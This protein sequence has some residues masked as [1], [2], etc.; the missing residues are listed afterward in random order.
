MFKGKRSQSGGERTEEERRL[1]REER[2]R[3]RGASVSSDP[4]VE[5]PSPAQPIGGEVGEPSGGEGG[6][7]TAEEAPPTVEHAMP[8][9]NEPLALAEQSELTEPFGPLV[10]PFSEE[11]IPASPSEA[12]MPIE[13][14]E[15]EE[16]PSEELPAQP[17]SVKP[18]VPAAPRNPR[19]AHRVNRLRRQ[20]ASSHR[21]YRRWAI[22]ILALLA[23]AAVVVAVLT[24]A[25]SPGDPKPAPVLP[26][27]VR[28]TIPEGFT[29]AQIAA[30][31]KADGLQG[32][33]L[34]ASVRSSLLHPARYGAPSGTQT[35]EGFLF[36][37]TY[38]LYAGV[39]AT[40]LVDEQLL[41]FR[42][43][44]NDVEIRRARALGLTPY[45]LLTVASMVEREAATA[46]DRPLVAAVVYNRL[47]LNMPLGID[48]TIRYALND[49]SKPLT[50]AQLHDPS[51]YNTR[52]HTGLPPTPISNP[53]AASI[54]AA[55]H[56]AHVSYLYYV[57]G[58]DGCGELVFSSGIAEF[59]RNAAAY[60][61]AIAK[62]H[63]QVPTCHKK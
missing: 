50:E 54:H 57:A 45:Q 51:P 63:G 32:S 13:H 48:A 24:L 3:R 6:A 43:N 35:L 47:R 17:P 36:P 41:A 19:V 56:P 52:L 59:E 61:E 25:Q 16:P 20:R 46:H 26:K 60:R 31:A 55:A 53:G 14:A 34:A 11:P 7:Q 4:P 5:G 9:P 38:E 44:F 42:E 39:P 15:P 1:A 30:L 10:E 22:R 40:H 27:I 28:V 37:A 49:F 18:V 12:P 23:L 21:W 62:N 29:R 2:E 33:Y 58:A 8:E